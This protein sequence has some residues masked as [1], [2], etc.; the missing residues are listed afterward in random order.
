MAVSKKSLENLEKGK[1]FSSNN[2]PENRGRKPS[3]LRFIRDEGMS[4]TDIK[5]I[6]G[7]L[8][9]DYDRTELTALLNDKNNPPCMGVSIVLGALIDDQKKKCANNFEKLMDRAYGRPTQTIIDAIAPI[10]TEDVLKK[11]SD[12]ELL[13]VIG[14][15]KIGAK[16]KQRKS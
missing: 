1:K 12:S 9:W 13:E 4:I 7:S 6:I 5:R 8:I 11:L 10:E 15:K 3:A 2:Q 14:I 16:K